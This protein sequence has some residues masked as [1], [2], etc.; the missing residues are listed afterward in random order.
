MDVFVVEHVVLTGFDPEYV[1]RE[2]AGRREWPL[3]VFVA[4]TE[5]KARRWCV[6][7]LDYEEEVREDE[8]W[9]FRI[10]R[11]A[12]DRDVWHDPNASEL[13]P[14]VDWTGEII[15]VVPG[16]TS[17]IRRVRTSA[18][19]KQEVIEAGVVVD[20]EDDED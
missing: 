6:R 9:Y 20:E 11:R 1:F 8:Y 7:N 14:G 5:Q 12:L 15:P 2:I 18:D 3:V 16:E 19:G 10:T 13:M 4:S 17:E